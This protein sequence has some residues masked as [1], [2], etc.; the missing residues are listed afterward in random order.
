MENNVQ[1]LIEMLDNMVREARSVPLSSDKCMLERDK[2]L[3]L[4]DSIKAKLPTEMAEAKRLVDARAEFIANA[5]REAENVRH[6][7]EERA[8]QLVNEQAV[9]RDAQ[10]KSEKML[11]DARKNSAALKQAASSYAGDMLVRTEDSI[12]KALKEIRTLRSQVTNALNGSAPEAK[13]PEAKE[14][15]EIP[16]PAERAAEEEEVSIEEEEL[17]VEE[18]D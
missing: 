2:V 16:E 7:A 3:D 6:A 13:M 9:Y 5:K 14:T 1:E 12:E 18:D 11:S 10:L 15:V 17:F 8:R 4:L